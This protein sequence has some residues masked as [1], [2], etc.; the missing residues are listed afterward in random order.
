VP[1]PRVANDFPN[2]YKGVLTQ[3]LVLPQTWSING[4]EGLGY[5][6]SSILISLLLLK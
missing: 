3:N 2:V 5:Y 6:S 4:T 1:G